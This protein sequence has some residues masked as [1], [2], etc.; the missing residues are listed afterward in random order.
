M[1]CPESADPPGLP[2]RNGCSQMLGKFAPNWKRVP[3]PRKSVRACSM[4]KGRR[5][6]S[7]FE[8]P[9]ATKKISQHFACSARKK[10]CRQKKC[11]YCVH[12]QVMRRF[13]WR[14]FSAFRNWKGPSGSGWKTLTQ[15]VTTSLC[16]TAHGEL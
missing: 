7:S 9:P 4:K 14:T 1:K 16:T 10:L 12:W 2:Q 11:D 13:L 6:Q 5:R 15:L 8:S 3:C